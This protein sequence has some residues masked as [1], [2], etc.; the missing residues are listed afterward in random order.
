MAFAAVIRLFAIL[1]FTEHKFLHHW[2]QK[3][4]KRAENKYKGENI[5]LWTRRE[6]RPLLL[7][8]EARGDGH[9]HFEDG[10]EAGDFA[11]VAGADDLSVDLQASLVVLRR[12]APADLV[13]PVQDVRRERLISELVVERPQAFGRVVQFPLGLRV[14]CRELA[15]LNQAV[16][17]G[18][19]HQMFGRDLLLLH[20]LGRQLLQELYI[21]F[22]RG[23]WRHLSV[24]VVG[25]RGLGEAHHRSSDRGWRSV[26]IWHLLPWSAPH[27]RGV[28]PSLLWPCWRRGDGSCREGLHGWSAGASLWVP[29]PHGSVRRPCH[30]RRGR[31][32]VVDDPRVHGDGGSGLRT[33]GRHG[34]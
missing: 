19:K 23:P 34:T 20:A 31:A 9:E 28:V 2:V 26:V 24:E 32:L 29:R 12:H 7:D 11:E 8:P 18:F 30:R 25:L 27:S 15:P 17:G 3:E 4:E 1:H 14:P 16:E 22:L 13:E 6:W 21:G 33:R 10:H 5:T